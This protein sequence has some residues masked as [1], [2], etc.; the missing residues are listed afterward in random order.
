MTGVEAEAAIRVPVRRR[1]SV[2]AACQVARFFGFG[3]NK[4]APEDEEKGRG[5]GR[6]K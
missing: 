4:Q 2:P 5:K 1:L 6:G 3:R